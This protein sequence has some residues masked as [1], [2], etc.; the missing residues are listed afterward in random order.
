MNETRVLDFERPI[1]E[2]EGKIRELKGLLAGGSEDM[3]KEIARLEAKASELQREHYAQL[4]PWEQLQLAKHP[5]RPYTLDYIGEMTTDFV[6]LRGD[7][8]YRDDPAIVGGLCRLRGRRVLIMGHQKGRNT[9]EN[10]FRNF[11]M[12]RPEGYRKAQR[13]M[14]LAEQFGL[15]VL[16]LID[17]A[18][19]YPGIGAEERGQAEAIAASLELMA[20]LKV[21]TISVV[22]GEGGSGGALAIG[23]TNRILMLE[24]SVYSV[25]SPRGCAS[26]LWKNAEAEQTAAEQLRMTAEDLLN[27]GVCDGIVREAIGGAH[28]GLTV[29]AAALEQA[30]SD[31]LDQLAKLSTEELVA[32]RYAKFRA[33][34][35]IEQA[36]AEASEG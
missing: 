27:L 5:D 9:K 18:G 2:L 17:T 4:S 7:R 28:R 1:V 23:V 22:I 13:L 31:H 12:A 19:A 10:V 6:E 34:G 3:A 25:I 24:H 15:P 29:T 32:D 20:A 35:H 21:P 26:I 33:I 36:A 14:K 11:G 8:A 16:C 30:L